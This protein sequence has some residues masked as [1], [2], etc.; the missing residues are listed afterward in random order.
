MPHESLGI[1]TVYIIHFNTVYVY[2]CMCIYI[3][4]HGFTGKII[5]NHF[6]R[7]PYVQI[8]LGWGWPRPNKDKDPWQPLGIVPGHHLILPRSPA[9]GAYDPASECTQ[10]LGSAGSVLR[11]REVY[12]TRIQYNIIPHKAVLGSFKDSQLL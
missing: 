3:H 10:D 11:V 5:I 7:V 1:Y 6:K 2:V 9:Y 12:D 4:T 8:H